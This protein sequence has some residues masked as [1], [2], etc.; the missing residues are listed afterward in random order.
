MIVVKTPGEIAGAEAS[1]AG[2]AAVVSTI[3]MVGYGL[4]SCDGHILVSAEEGSGSFG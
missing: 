2:G 3:V 4:G 1:V